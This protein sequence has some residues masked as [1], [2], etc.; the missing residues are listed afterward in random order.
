MGGFLCWL[1]PVLQQQQ[2]LPLQAGVVQASEDLDFGLPLLSAAVKS[3][4]AV[5]LALG[6]P[7]GHVS[8]FPGIP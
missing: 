7:D 5:P 3:V 4:T 6:C 1:S 2:L 8:S